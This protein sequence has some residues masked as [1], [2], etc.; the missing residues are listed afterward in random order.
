MRPM[1]TRLLVPLDGSK[2]AEA[3]LPVAARMATLTG[4]AI[5]LLHVI[6]KDAPSSVH[7]DHHLRETGE[8]ERYLDGVKEGLA[9]GGLQVFSHVHTVP[10][11]NVPLCIAEHADELDQDLVVICRH[12][13][14]GFRQFVFGSNAERVL[15]HGTTPVLLVQVDETGKAPRF[16]PEH[17]LVL[18]EGAG[19]GGATTRA[20]AEVALRAH[21]TLHLLSVVPTLASVRAE[22]AAKGRL[23]PRATS[24]MLDL[25]AEEAFEWLYDEVRSLVARGV[26][27]TGSVERGET[28]SRVVA[29]AGMGAVDLVVV[30]TRGLSGLSALWSDDV[31]RKVA[32]AY[33][34]VLLLIPP[35]GGGEPE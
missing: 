5:H 24:H 15:S 13:S 33:T 14:G 12:G 1:F 17:I 16:G 3:V 19:G 22:E 29:M 30:P 34:G 7:G 26:R 4:G 28:A 11:G 2:L 32:N 6:E 31:A 18:T 25:A 8:A 23:A 20:G 35:E 9:A 10:Q 27:A 21:A